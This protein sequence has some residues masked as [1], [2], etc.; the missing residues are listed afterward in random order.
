MDGIASLMEMW[1]LPAV[2]SALFLGFYDITKKRSLDGNA[3]I[4]VLS[5]STIAGAVLFI[6][7]IIFSYTGNMHPA[8]S[9]FYV[10]V[11]TCREHLFILLKSFIVIISWILAYFAFKNLPVTIAAPIRTSGPLFTI[12]GA[13]L[14]FGELLTLWQWLGVVITLIFLQLFAHAGRREGIEFKK[15]KWVVFMYL[16]T[17]IGSLST[18]YDKYLMIRFNRI[19]VQAWYSVYMMIIMAIVCLVLWYPQRTKS[20]RFTWRW[21]ILLIGLFLSISD[22]TYFYSLSVPGSLVTIITIIRRSGVLV[23]FF[24]GGM[25]FNEANLRHKAVILAGILA[26]IA[27]VILGS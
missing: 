23:T 1:T 13:L 17:F 26:G 24:V 9:A 10:P 4:P 6:P 11:V 12:L 19:A 2:L 7:L 25:M 16:S 3:V 5:F 18:L 21:Q 8:L 15:N 14:L 27:I 20:T 22:F